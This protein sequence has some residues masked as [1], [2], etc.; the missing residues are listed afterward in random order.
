[1]FFLLWRLK[2]QEKHFKNNVFLTLDAGKHFLKMIFLFFQHPKL[3][4]PYF[5]NAFPAFYA[6]RCLRPYPQGRPSG[7]LVGVQALRKHKKQEKHLKNKVFLALEG[8]KARKA[9]K[10]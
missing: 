7:R 8:E 6:L 3:E 9:F 5:L 10:K 1:M 4:K 2:K